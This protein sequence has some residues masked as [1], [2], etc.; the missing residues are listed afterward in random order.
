MNNLNNFCTCRLSFPTVAER[1][2]WFSALAE[3]VA[4]AIMLASGGSSI[5][6]ENSKK[7]FENPS[8]TRCADCESE[9]KFDVLPIS[10]RHDYMFA[11][12][13]AFSDS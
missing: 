6:C 9:G 1:D 8:N 4:D 5:A 2:Q 13:L 3:A 10:S 7:I 12:T 11:E